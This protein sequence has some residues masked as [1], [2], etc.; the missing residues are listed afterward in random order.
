[1][2]VLDHEDGYQRQIHSIE[3]TPFRTKFEDDIV[4]FHGTSAIGCISDADPQ[5]LL[6]RSHLG[7]FAI[8][9]SV[10]STMPRP[11]WKSISRITMRSLWRSALAR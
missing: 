8:T 4:R 10:P 7:T 3:N 11:W 9:T 1:M 6:V 2:I 5:P